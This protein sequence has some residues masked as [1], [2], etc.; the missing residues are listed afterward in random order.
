[1]DVEDAARA[2]GLLRPKITV[3]MH[4]DTFPLIS[5]DPE[6]FASLLRG[7]TEVRIL[8]PGEALTL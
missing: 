5:A 8:D 1:M 6:H 2:V 4:Y 3:P 7:K